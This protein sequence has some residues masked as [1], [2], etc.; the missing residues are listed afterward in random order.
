[1]KLRALILPI[2][3]I[4]ASN[5]VFAANIEGT[6]YDIELKSRL[7]QYKLTEI[8]GYLYFQF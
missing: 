8:D 2:L 1:M 4:L 6:I 5:I 3:L 7:I